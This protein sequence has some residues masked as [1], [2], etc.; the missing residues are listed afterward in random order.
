MINTCML[1]LLLKFREVN[2]V[3]V[4]VGAGV[5]SEHCSTLY[6]WQSLYSHNNNRSPLS[7][8]ASLMG[9]GGG[10]DGGGGADVVWPAQL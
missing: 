8:T 4:M 9:S 7:S 1:K 10:G 3:G 5:V 6:G 2:G